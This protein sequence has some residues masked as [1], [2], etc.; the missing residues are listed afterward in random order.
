MYPKGIFDIDKS[1]PLKVQPIPAQNVV[2]LTTYSQE[3]KQFNVEITDMLGRLQ[4]QSL[5]NIEF[6]ENRI[7]L[8]ISNLN[9]GSYF[10]Q[11]LDR[12]R[13]VVF[14]SKILVQR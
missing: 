8:D 5:V 2:Y 12:N 14:E 7:P 4:L 1:A 13:K 9:N 3:R 10:L 6:G 11:C